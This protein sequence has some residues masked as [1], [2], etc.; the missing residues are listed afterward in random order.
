MQNIKKM[1]RF[2]IYS[3]AVL[4]IALNITLHN[5]LCLDMQTCAFF[6]ILHNTVYI[7]INNHLSA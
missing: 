1:H 2:A 7:S 5:D 6:L 3:L 4:N